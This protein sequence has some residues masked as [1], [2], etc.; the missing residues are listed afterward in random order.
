MA[1]PEPFPNPIIRRCVVRQME[2][3]VSNQIVQT[4]AIESGSGRS[5]EIGRTLK[6]ALFGQVIHAVILAPNGSGHY[7]RTDSHMAIKV[8]SKRSL[9][10]FQGKTEENPLREITALQFLGDYPTQQQAGTVGHSHPNIMGQIE[11]C[12]DEENIYSVMRYCSGGELFDYV[13]E[14]GPMA[15]P[16]AKTMFL[17][18][19]SAVEHLHT[20]GIGHRDISLENILYDPAVNHFIVIDF[21]MCIR[22]KEAPL[23]PA[24]A[25]SVD[26][27]DNGSAATRKRFC[28]IPKQAICGK[29]NFIAPE[30]MD[31]E[32]TVFNPMLGDVWAMGVVLF[33]CLTGVPP[34]NQAIA[35][36]DKFRMICYENNLETLVQM[37]G[38]E[39]QLSTT[40]VDLIKSILRLQPLDRLT[41]DQI[42]SHPWLQQ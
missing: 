17:Q 4:K 31:P 9:R 3:L 36:D 11:C 39:D 28:L 30:V 14:A 2:V 12:T 35:T 10:A 13:Y 5:Y 34:M 19:L 41:I 24:K 8:F 33:I 18:M 15:E 42:R 37:W 40:V 27:S 38:L 21:G 22:C 23:Q 29:K 1:D 7:I 20:L 25:P 16:L 6:K 32:V 26:G